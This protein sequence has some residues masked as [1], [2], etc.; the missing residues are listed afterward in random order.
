LTAASPYYDLA[1]N[2][3]NFASDK[4]R[5]LAR[6]IEIAQ[7][8]RNPSA[9]I[10]PRLRVF[11]KQRTLHFD[12][13]FEFEVNPQNWTLAAGLVRLAFYGADFTPDGDALP[14]HWQVSSQDGLVRTPEGITFDLAT[15]DPFILAETFIYNIHS[16][17]ADLRGKVVVDGGAFIGDTALY[18]AQQGA[19]VYAY[20]PDPANFAALENNLR[21]NPKLAAQIR[22]FP[23][24]LGADATVEFHSRLGGGGGLFSKGGQVI[25]VRSVSL[26]T[27]LREN[28]LSWVSFLKIDC[29]GTEF[30]LVRQA[31]L[32]RISALGIEYSA[33][34]RRGTV[35]D[36]VE[37]LHRQGF[38]R[39]S[40]YKHH[41]M[42]FSLLRHGMIRAER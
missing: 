34:L 5:I 11:G 9:L 37:A 15:I 7:A 22:A 12:N 24:A 21:L 33:D 20:E 13:G 6:A 14:L 3:R 30:D 23:F 16:A 39:I 18:F 26:D 35:T 2:R 19:T 29:K 38:I 25:P 40:V 10:I 28:G 32:G 8:V 41:W 31:A 1:A 36:L 17:H 4:L 27:I 42:Y